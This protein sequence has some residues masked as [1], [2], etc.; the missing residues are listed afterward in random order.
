V[1]II[2]AAS[3]KVKNKGRV[4]VISILLVQLSLLSAKFD[5]LI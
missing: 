3:I 4:V 1:F 5:G 2:L